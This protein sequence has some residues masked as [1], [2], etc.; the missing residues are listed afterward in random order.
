[1]KFVSIERPLTFYGI[2]GVILFSIGIFFVIWTL[3]IFSEE[4]KIITNIALIGMGGLILGI[5]CIMTSVILYSI[6]SVVR[7]RN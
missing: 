2:P 3:D 7:E 4:G 6:V 5:L 1:M